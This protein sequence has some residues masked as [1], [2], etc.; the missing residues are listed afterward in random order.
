[1]KAKPWCW[2]AMTPEGTRGYRPHWRSGFYHLAATAK[3]PLVLVYID[4]PNKLLSVVDTLDLSG[5]Q[6]R[7]MAAIAA[8]YEGHHG[9]YPEREAPVV[10]APPTT[11]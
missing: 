8:V 1:M 3:V 7:D 2:I 5:D 11:G 10:L 9:L 4:Y 6:A